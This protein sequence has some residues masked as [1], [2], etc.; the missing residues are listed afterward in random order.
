[1]GFDTPKEPVNIRKQI[2]VRNIMGSNIRI[3]WSL[4]TLWYRSS[5]LQYL[6]KVWKEEFTKR[7]FTWQRFLSYL[8]IKLMMLSFG[9]LTRFPRRISWRRCST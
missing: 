2:L 6:W 4:L 3:N 8:I 1:M 7:E 9:L 5:F